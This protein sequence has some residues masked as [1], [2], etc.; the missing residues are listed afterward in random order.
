MGR[1]GS[2]ITALDKPK[3]VVVRAYGNTRSTQSFVYV[4]TAI[5]KRP[6]LTGLEAAWR[7]AAGVPLLCVAG[8]WLQCNWT[9]FMA[10]LARVEAL[11]FLRPVH[12]LEVLGSVYRT[13]APLLLP[14]LTWFLP[15]V[16]V[17]WALAGTAGRFVSSKRLQA[18]RRFAWGAVFLFRLVRIV[19]VLAMWA[20]W[21]ALLAWA[22]RHT[23][24][25][26]AMQ[27]QEPNVV[28]F[29]GYIIP[30]SLALFS[31]WAA[32]SWPLTL[33]ELFSA[34]EGLGFAASFGKALTAGSLR[35]QVL[36][37]NLV[38]C[39]VRLALLVLAMVFTACPLPF[40]SVATKNFLVLW[41]SFIIILYLLASDYFHVVRFAAY[42]AFSRASASAN[43]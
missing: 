8:L 9:T 29:M 27:G 4:M 3:E 18:D 14:T 21:G 17:I 7:W 25:I 24:S 36:E 2:V 10:Q 32:V 28:G 34:T 30:G 23:V 11:S 13:L 40:E 26:P 39:I 1:E 12:G 37:V 20:L 38:F 33:A 41:T 42:D 15:V 19:G 22:A 43:A 6:G 35:A 16:V 31:G 5:W